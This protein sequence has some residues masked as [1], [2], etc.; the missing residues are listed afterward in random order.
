MKFLSAGIFLKET[1]I[2]LSKMFQFKAFR[3]KHHR[4]S[5]SSDIHKA[6]LPLLPTGGTWFCPW[7]LAALRVLVDDLQSWGLWSSWS[8]FR[9]PE[10][11]SDPRVLMVTKFSR[12]RRGGGELAG[13]Q[14]VL[15]WSPCKVIENHHPFSWTGNFW[16]K[17]CFVRIFLPSSSLWAFSASSPCPY[18]CPRAWECQGQQGLQSGGPTALQKPRKGIFQ[19]EMGQAAESF[20]MGCG[21][22]GLQDTHPAATRSHCTNIAKIISGT[23]QGCCSKVPFFWMAK[24]FLFWS[25]WCVW[26]LL[27]FWGFCWVLFVWLVLVWVF[28][29]LVGWLV[30]VVCSFFSKPILFSWEGRYFLWVFLWSWELDCHKEN[31]NFLD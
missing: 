31:Q 16:G 4:G 30:N 23:G 12:E 7:T 15:C 2:K 28:V 10:A 1:I 20:L 21:S 11:F 29:L 26:L 17:I 24:T 25:N 8:P 14:T 6:P 19:A 5:S 9:K 22:L 27:L 18:P 13:K 3:R